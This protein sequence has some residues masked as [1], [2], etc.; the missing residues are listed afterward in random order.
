MAHA[1]TPGLRV[2]GN[3]IVRRERR[4]PLKGEVLAAMGDAVAPDTVV[5]RANL[6]GNVVAMG[7]SGKLGVDP[8]RVIG[9]LLVPVGAVV[10]QG[11]RI[12]EAKGLFGLVRTGVESPVDGTIESVSSATGQLLL[13]EPPVPVEVAA[14][15]RG[16]IV[17]VL[18][19]EGVVVEARGAQIG[20]AHV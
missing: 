16:T 5:A 12:A 13:R 3:A 9:T 10:R 4:L 6:P 11:E 8:G 7:L 18:P 17:D 20:R 2:T 19:E 14:Y 1:Y 15:V